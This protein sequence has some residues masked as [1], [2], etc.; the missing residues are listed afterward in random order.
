M[1]DRTLIDYIRLVKSHLQL[2]NQRDAFII[3]QHAMVEYPDSPFI[4]SYYGYMQ[5]AFG[6]KYRIGIETC[7]RA[8]SMIETNALPGK[9]ISP[10]LYLNLGR[11][12]IAAGKRKNA[13]DV[14]LRGLKHD[15]NEHILTELHSIGMRRKPFVPFLNRANPINKYIGMMLYVHGR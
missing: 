12:Y 7:R 14:F 13:V 4:L 3:L 6:R 5:A 1:R 2:G 11:A 9:E 15:Q 8:L 10:I